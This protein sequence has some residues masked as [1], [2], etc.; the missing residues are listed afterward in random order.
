MFTGI[1][2]HLPLPPQTQVIPTHLIATS[3]ND[4]FWFWHDIAF[5]G[6]EGVFGMS[7]KTIGRKESMVLL[8][9]ER[10]TRELPTSK[11]NRYSMAGGTEQRR[12]SKR[13]RKEREKEVDRREKK[14]NLSFILFTIKLDTTQIESYKIGL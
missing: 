6:H 9:T 14:S 8:H 1:C 4:M 12:Q 13:E 3:N 11:I 10:V 5:L 7:W 2:M